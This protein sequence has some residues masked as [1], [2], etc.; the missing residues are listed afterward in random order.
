VA[1]V[2]VTFSSTSQGGAVLFGACAA[3]SC[4]VTTDAQGRAS[5]LV[6]GVVPGVLTLVATAGLATGAQSLTVPFLVVA[7]QLSVT[8][9]NAQTF[10]TA[11]AMIGITVHGVAIEN[12]SPAVN[13]AVQWT[14]ATGFHSATAS[15]MTDAT[16]MNSVLA[17]LGPL[18][19]QDT[20]SMSA[21][22][23][24]SVCTQFTGTGVAASDL[25]VVLVRGGQQRVTGTPVPVVAMV[26]DGAGHPVAAAPVS[27]YQTVTA[28]D[29][30][31]PSSGR[32]SAAPILASQA[33]VV[34]S[35][36]D[37]TVTI[38]PLGVSGTATQTEIAFSVGT[39]GF[40]TAVVAVQP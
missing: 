6:T 1:G 29:G 33:I 35:G 27:I 31:C 3:A 5:S 25:S 22:A 16:G 39:A 20:A 34:V 13:Q 19:A 12:G 14:G 15:G 37:G 30:A 24:T 17:M 4:T 38:V 11:G 9:L 36:M 40:T 18:A 26:V 28:L 32:C 10:V 23:W 8:A 21:C 7:N 2:S